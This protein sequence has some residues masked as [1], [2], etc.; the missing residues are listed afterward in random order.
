[1]SRVVCED[2]DQ[3]CRAALSA[4]LRDGVHAS[5]RG[6]GVREL[7]APTV[8]TLTDPR[9]PIMTSLARKANYRFGLSEA[10]WICSGSDDLSRVA[11]FNRKMRKFSDDGKTLWGAYGPRVIG[12]LPHVIASLKRDPDSRQAI[13]TTW[14]PMV[15]AVD[16]VVGSYASQLSSGG[17]V[18]ANDTYTQTPVW[19]GFSWRSKDTPCTVAWHFMLRNDRLNLTVFMRSNDAW[20]GT[21]YD[22]LSFTT[23]QR[24]V[25]SILGVELGEYH[26]VVSNLHL[27][28]EH[29]QKAEEL[30]E[31]TEMRAS[32]TLMDFEFK[33]VERMVEAFSSV[34]DPEFY[35]SGDPGVDVYG[36]VIHQQSGAIGVSVR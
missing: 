19:D 18:H 7:T 34:F 35:T 1:M 8:I 20:L 4:V 14:R 25:A 24:S 33:S 15:D 5:P 6:I 11:L 28:D 27:Y 13:L 21:P 17:L 29:I 3:F 36:A 9:A 32:P 31:S 2:G 22:L 23:V 30:L 12:Q 10:A 16:C 26:H